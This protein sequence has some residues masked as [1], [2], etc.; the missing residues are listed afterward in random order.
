MSISIG[1]REAIPWVDM[2][3]KSDAVFSAWRRI[4]EWMF[5]LPPQETEMEEEASE[6]QLQVN[7]TRAERKRETAGRAEPSLECS[8][9]L[10]SGVGTELL[11]KSD[12]SSA[13][14]AARRGGSCLGR[15]E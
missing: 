2:I 13:G 14:F 9:R 5:Y 1:L 3:G 12:F 4:L 10:V 11:A 6:G 7:K 8:N 15:V